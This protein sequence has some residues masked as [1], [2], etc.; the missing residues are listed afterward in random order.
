MSMKRKKRKKR[1]ELN[2]KEKEIIRVLHHYGGYMTRNEIAE[3]TG[4]SFATV[5]KYI[6]KLLKE[7][8]VEEDER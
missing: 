4:I 6:K 2:T 5:D 1:P 8:V 7:G 3:K